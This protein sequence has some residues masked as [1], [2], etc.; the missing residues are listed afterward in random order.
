MYARSLANLRTIYKKENFILYLPSNLS[1]F[2]V[3][4]VRKKVRKFADFSRFS[5]FFLPSKIAN[6][7]FSCAVLR[8]FSEQN[9]I[10]YGFG[11]AGIDLKG[12]GSVFNKGIDDLLENVQ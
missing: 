11:F 4:K 6:F 8:H 5:V 2:T 7:E 12:Y 3:E 10:F 1:F 9:I